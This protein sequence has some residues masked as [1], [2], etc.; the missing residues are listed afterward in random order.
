MKTK[1]KKQ[2]VA[3]ANQETHDKLTPQQKI[4]KLDAKFGVGKGAKKER[5][6][7]IALYIGLNHL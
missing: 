7:L 6:R 4:A 1:E 2:E 3:K 5:A